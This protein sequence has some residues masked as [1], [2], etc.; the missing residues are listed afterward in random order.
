GPT[1]NL[2]GNVHVVAVY[3]P[4]AGYVALYTNGVLA[5]INTAV[6]HPLASTLGADPLNF[7]GASLYGAD[8]LLN[9]TIN[10]FRI[11]NGP[12]TAGQIA[13]DHALGP[14]QLI[15]ASTTVKLNV[16]HTNNNAVVTWPTTSALVNLMSSP[17]L[18][19]GASWTATDMSSLTVMGTNYQVTVPSSSS[20]A[21]FR[22]QQ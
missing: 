11:Y 21:F 9:A 6:T 14:D 3:H 22:L 15:G 17:A 20:A 10:E 7:L 1:T 4:Y 19:A 2:L 16:K 8:P 5:V 12:L 13:A 18:G